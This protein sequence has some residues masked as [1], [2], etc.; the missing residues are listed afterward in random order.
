MGS[1]PLLMWSGVV[2]R[3]PRCV[4]HSWL[5]FLWRLRQLSPCKTPAPLLGTVLV[6][7]VLWV[8]FPSRVTPP[9]PAPSL[10]VRGRAPRDVLRLVRSP[11]LVLSA[12]HLGTYPASMARVIVRTPSIVLRLLLSSWSLLSSGIL[13]L[14]RY[15][16]AF[17]E[18]RIVSTCCSRYW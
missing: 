8:G 4:F 12:Y 18:T 3:S 5:L 1:R 15:C 9:F 11:F 16:L 14:D 13:I 2:L 6:R 17:S 7:L 10:W